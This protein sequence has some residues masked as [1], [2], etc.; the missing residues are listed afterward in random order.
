M[1]SLRFPSAFVFALGLTT[2]MFWSMSILMNQKVDKAELRT[3][4]RIEFTRLRHDSEVRTRVRQQKAQKVE[5]AQVQNTPQISI[6]LG[7]GAGKMEVLPPNIDTSAV[8]SGLSLGIGGDGAGV[9]GGAAASDRDV[10]PLVRIEPDYPARAAQRGIEG[11]VVVRFTIS[12][13]GTIKDATVVD[14]QPK[15]IFDSAALQ[16][17]SRWKYKPK[18]E[19]GTPVERQGVQVR[20]AF[21]LENS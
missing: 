21:Q 10:V 2:L 9:G 17:V 16:A 12:A 11:Y 3:A 1:M 7:Q 14:A 19:N 15:D 18:I 8:L 5:T 6:N 4:T 13:A 20:L